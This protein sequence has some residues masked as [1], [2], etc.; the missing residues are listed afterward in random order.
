[1]NTTARRTGE[2]KPGRRDLA[3][4]K[5]TA[6]TAIMLN[7]IFPGVGLLYLGHRKHAFWN[8]L[9]AYTLLLGLVIW[10]EPKIMEHIHWFI[11]IVVVGSVSLAR[12][13]AREDG[14]R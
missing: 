12:A 8:A 1:M 3:K 2:P 6:W 4:E 7:A 5:K 13:F 10:S 14:L 11:M 9:I